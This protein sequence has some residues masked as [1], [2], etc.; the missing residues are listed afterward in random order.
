VAQGA[1]IHKRLLIGGIR[2]FEFT[3][4]FVGTTM[5]SNTTGDR[6]M[7]AAT[8]HE[9]DRQAFNAA[10]YALGLRWFWDEPTYQRLLQQPCERQRVREYVET[11]QAHLL[12][13]YDAE[14]LAD[15]VLEAKRRDRDLNARRVCAPAWAEVGV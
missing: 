11:A 1:G 14:F 15:A 2:S 13:A 10:F 5:R 12:R 6:A 9:S 8:A 3:L 7:T 4:S